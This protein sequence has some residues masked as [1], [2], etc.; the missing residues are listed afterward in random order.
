VRNPKKNKKQK[1]K[2]KIKITHCRTLGARNFHTKHHTRG[3]EQNSPT[4]TKKKITTKKTSIGLVS[5]HGKK[6]MN[7]KG[8]GKK[9]EEKKVRV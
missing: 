5:D 7:P 3:T 1:T 8:G 4:T 9:K 2:S 6:G